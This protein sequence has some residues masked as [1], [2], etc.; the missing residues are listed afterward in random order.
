MVPFYHGR[1]GTQR[2]T[3]SGG[4]GAQPGTCPL[5][6]GNASGSPSAADDDLMQSGGTEEEDFSDL[7][8]P[9]YNQFIGIYSYTVHIYIDGSASLSVNVVQ[10]SKMFLLQERRRHK[11]NVQTWIAIVAV[12]ACSSRHTHTRP[13]G[14]GCNTHSF[15]EWVVMV[16][17]GRRENLI[18][19]KHLS[20]GGCSVSGY[21][22]ANSDV[23]K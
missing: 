7:Y 19:W 17:S 16:E 4:P 3:K 21:L 20:E 11:I 2:W 14:R 18:M 10:Q 9:S 5:H 15:Q 22:M 6:R 12:R 23:F 8:S 1:A 13:K